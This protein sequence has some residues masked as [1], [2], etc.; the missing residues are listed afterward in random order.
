M[1]WVDDFDGESREHNVV[2]LGLDCYKC[3]QCIKPAGISSES[4]TEIDNVMKSK[5]VFHICLNIL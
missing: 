3:K 1:Y 4:I 2:P 5:A